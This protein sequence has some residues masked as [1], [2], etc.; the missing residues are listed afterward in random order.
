MDLRSPSSVAAAL[1][2]VAEAYLVG[3]FKDTNFCVIHAK[4][5]TIIPKD[6]QL[7]RRIRGERD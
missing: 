1:Q 6:I 4:R 2:E 5:V 3:L 7:A